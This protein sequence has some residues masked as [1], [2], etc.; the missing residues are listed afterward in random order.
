VELAFLLPLLC[1]LAVVATDFA[2]IFYYDLTVYNCARD[3]ALWA[4]DPIQ[5]AQSPYTNVTDAALADA[6]NLTPQP[7]V[8][9]TTSGGEVVVTVTYQFQTVTN[10]PGIAHDWSVSR[11]VRMK[12]VPRLPNF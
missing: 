1:F 3:G 7:T 12:T 6:S 2:Q 4:C 10:Y 9:Q 5:Q 8:T 11:T